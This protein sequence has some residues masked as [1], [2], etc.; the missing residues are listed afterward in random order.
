[1]NLKNKISLIISALFAIIF[2]I[3]ATVIYTLF[4]DFRQEE[5]EIR[6]KEKAISS[7]KILVDVEEVDHQLLK[8][9]DQNSIHKLYNEKI[10]IFNSKFEL[11]YSSLDDTKIRWD[12]NDLNY[13]KTNKKFYRKESDQEVFGI[14][15]D[16]HEHDYYALISASDDFGKRKLLYLFYILVSTYIIFTI[17]CWFTTTYVVQRLLFP[18]DTFYKTLK[19]INENNLKTRIEVKTKKDE[20][21]LLANE[22]NQMLQRIDISYQKQKEFTAHASHELRTP[23]ARILAQIENRILEAGITDIEKNYLKNLITDINQ[24]SDLISSLL[25]LSKIDSNNKVENEIC[26]IDELIFE[27]AENVRITYPTIR[28]QLDIKDSETDHHTFE[29]KGNK[30]LLEIAF[31]NLIKNAYQYSDNKI[32]QIAIYFQEEQLHVDFSNTGSTIAEN[33]KATLFDP[34]MR[35]ENSKNKT[36]FGLGLRIVQHIIIQHKAEI[37]YFITEVN[38]NTFRLK[39]ML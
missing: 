25:L 15:Y 36:G 35:G 39:F 27:S 38:V 3:S 4:A 32:V 31:T 13:L 16:T 8:I 11:I 28:L 17:I 29:I 6:L 34:F 5:F 14:F 30:T 19:G 20:I 9:I 23:I 26:R 18:I 21:D 22:F 10:L 12:K 37:Q 24:I 33:E 7:I 1:M 2:A